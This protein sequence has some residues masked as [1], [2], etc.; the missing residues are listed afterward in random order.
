MGK[1]LCWSLFSNEVAILSGGCNFA[2]SLRTPFFIEYPN[3]YFC[4]L[5]RQAM[6]LLRDNQLIKVIPMN[7]SSCILE[8]YLH[9]YRPSKNL[10]SPFLAIYHLL[11]NYYFHH[12][13]QYLTIISKLSRIFLVF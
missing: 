11:F 9:L 8:I 2:N 1:H 10:S 12:F 4:S 3:G 7:L 13:C 5:Q 6:C